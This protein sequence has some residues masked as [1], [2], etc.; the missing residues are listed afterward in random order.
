MLENL[1]GGDEVVYASIVD[2]HIYD[3]NVTVL[4]SSC[5]FKGVYG[6]FVLMFVFFYGLVFCTLDNQLI[7]HKYTLTDF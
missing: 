4:Q 5:M 1:C 3:M 2:S 7:V 6:C